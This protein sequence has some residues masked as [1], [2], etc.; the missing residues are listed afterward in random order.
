MSLL[1]WLKIEHTF[2]DIWNLIL[3]AEGNQQG[4]NLM[5]FVETKKKTKGQIVRFLYK[6]LNCNVYSLHYRLL[7][8]S[9][10]ASRLNPKIIKTS[11]LKPCYALIKRRLLQ[12]STKQRS[13]DVRFWPKVCQIDIK[14]DKL[15]T[16]SDRIWK[17]LDLSLWGQSEPLWAQIWHSWCVELYYSTLHSQNQE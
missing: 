10:C 1:P 17:V 14:W 9:G 3:F 16:F 8:L 13:G 12:D 5:W 4:L 6:S 15:D 2:G 11:N 7:N